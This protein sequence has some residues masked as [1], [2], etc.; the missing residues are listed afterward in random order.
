M[1]SSKRNPRSAG[2]RRVTSTGRQRVLWAAVSF[3]TAMAAC[4]GSIPV[5]NASF[6]SPATDYALPM[7]DGWAT[8]PQPVWYDEGQWG[9]PWYQ[10]TG[11]FLNAEPLIDNMDGNQ[12][13][14]LFALPEVGVFQDYNSMD[15]S[16]AEP[17]HAFAVTYEPGL[18]YQL[19]VGVVGNGGGMQEG[20][21]LALRLYYLD[22]TGQP[23][24]AAETTVTNSAELF[25]DRQHFVEFQV[26]VPEVKAED[27]WAGRHLGIGIISTV[28]FEQPGGYWDV[29]KVQL[30]SI[31]R[32]RLEEP[33][34]ADGA[35]SF[36]VVGE[37]LTQYG[38][39]HTGGLVDP[40]DQWTELGTVT[41]G[42]DGRALFTHA[43]PTPEPRFYAA[44]QLP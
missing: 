27:A 5:P 18:A 33:A 41:T 14:F 32:P 44:Q 13:A 3:A 17:S 12:G 7:I 21:S 2:T 19:T 22:D 24:T 36:T 30:R 28:G 40:A 31:M 10:T 34:F 37:P 1:R 15:Y 4:A 16:Q 23:V 26:E 42:D 29:D 39:R 43:S 8:V 11:V 6:E 20:V 9:G 35:F 38:I 25:G